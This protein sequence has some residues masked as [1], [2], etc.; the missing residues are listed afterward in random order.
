MGL[1]DSKIKHY[2][3]G[4]DDE[5]DPNMALINSEDLFNDGPFPATTYEGLTIEGYLTGSQNSATSSSL[6]DGNFN[7]AGF[8]GVP[9]EAIK[10]IFDLPQVSQ[11]TLSMLV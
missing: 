4:A 10:I 3:Q 5:F 11:P 6:F 1:I 2:T 8:Q 7:G 9:S